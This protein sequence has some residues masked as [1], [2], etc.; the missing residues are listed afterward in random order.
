MKPLTICCA[1]STCLLGLVSP[2]RAQY[3]GIE[4]PGTVSG[5]G[6]VTLE[7]MPER[8][9]LQVAI[10]S[11]A[12]TLKEALDGLKDRVEAAKVQ[13]GTLG[14][15]KESITVGSPKITGAKSAQQQQM[16]QMVRARMK[17]SGRK[18][19]AAPEKK[20][21][22]VAAELKAE[23]KVT[24]KTVEE[25]P[26]ATY[27][28]QE[29]IKAAD[30]S[31]AKETTKVSAEEQ[32]AIDETESQFGG[33]SQDNESKPGEP[34]FLF[35][36]KFADNEID[37]AL[38]E[39]FQKAKANA[40]RIAKGAGAQLGPLSIVSHNHSSDAE[41]GGDFDDY[42]AGRSRYYQV[43]QR[44]RMGVADGDDSTAEAVGIQPDKVRYRVNVR[45]AFQLS[46][47]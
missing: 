38:A 19:P 30:L 28:L 46:A 44:A 25:L 9:R 26:L 11:K 1:I 7:R 33:S 3:G 23:W 47:K 42:G 35:V 37:K 34:I 8:M 22:V 39:G 43:M 36:T 13:L 18:Q 21:V 20:P 2:A 4:A 24:A 12:S 14:V 16:E 15:D 17:R 5:T 45:V 32:E 29:K 31:G 40:E 6:V 27:P 10:L 41:S